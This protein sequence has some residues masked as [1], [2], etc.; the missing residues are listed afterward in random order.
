MALSHA[1]GQLPIPNTMPVQIGRSL[2][3]LG[4]FAGVAFFA[5]RFY[6]QRQGPQASIFLF[7][8]P[9]NFWLSALYAGIG[10]VE[11]SRILAFRTRT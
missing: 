9:A 3:I 7:F 6:I 8:G 11:G 4:L 2:A 10:L 1:K 5:W